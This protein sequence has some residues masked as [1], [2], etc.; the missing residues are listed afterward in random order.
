MFGVAALALALA[1]RAAGGQTVPESLAADEDPY[2]EAAGLRPLRLQTLPHGTREIRAWL[3]GGLGWPQGLFRLVERDG[4]PSGEYIRYWRLDNHDPVGADSTTFAALLRYH[5]RGRCELLRR[6][7]SAEACRALFQREPDWSVVWRTADS[8]GVW[9]L[10]DASTLP[11]VVGPN[12]ERIVTV[13]GWG[14]TVEL[15]DGPAYR[16][17]HYGNPDTKPWPEAARATAFAAALR[18]VC[19]LM[20]RSAAERVYVG[21]C[22]V[23]ADTVEF[24]PCTGGGPWLLMG[25][26]E[27]LVGPRGRSGPPRPGSR[28]EVRGTLA[29]DWVAREWWHVPQ[30]YQRTLEVD[31][32]LAVSPWRIGECT[33]SDGRPP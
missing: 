28:V 14:I 6:G 27:R 18:T 15:R 29:P 30:R 5:E 12:G 20:R 21:R 19:A 26:V 10:P 4:R 13:D 11:E 17:W 22:D 31:S 32:V 24:T 2:A 3:G 33:R 1:G 7:P 16:A 9:S 8:L 23:R 25:R